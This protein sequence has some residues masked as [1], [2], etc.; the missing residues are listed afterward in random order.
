MRNQIIFLNG[1]SGSGKSSIAEELLVMLDD[2]YYRMSV[3]DINRMR[4]RRSLDPATVEAVLRRMRAGFHRAVA[5]MA[6]AG[7]K[8]VVDHVLS[9]PW[10]LVDCLAVLEPY[11]VMFVGVRCSLPELERRERARGDR[12]LGISANQ[13]DRVH[14]HGSYDLE[15]HTDQSSAAECA[16][17]I[18][19]YLDRE[20]RSQPAFDLLRQRYVRTE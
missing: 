8:V 2:V 7:N 10:R 15:V 3:D 13:F 1:A 6:A 9:E 17:Q 11:D 14:A 16:R 12:H 4:A 19:T 18:V 20:P 5:G